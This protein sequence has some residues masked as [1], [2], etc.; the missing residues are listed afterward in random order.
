MATL[1]HLQNQKIASG[2]IGY[3]LMNM[4]TNSS[5]SDAMIPW[6]VSYANDLEGRL[7]AGAR[8]ATFPDIINARLSS[9]TDSAAWRMPYFQTMSAEY[10]GL[11][12]TGIPLLVVAHGVGPMERLADAVDFIQ[13]T[14]HRMRYSERA[15]WRSVVEDA[16]KNLQRKRREGR[17]A[18]D[19]LHYID[20]NTER[21]ACRPQNPRFRKTFLDLVDGVYGDVHIIE[22]RTL[23]HWYR[24][25][26]GLSYDEACDDPLVRVRLGPRAEEYLS[27]LR[28]LNR[29]ISI[30]DEPI[31]Y[32]CITSSD[33]FLRYAD[34][35]R[36]PVGYL[37]DEHLNLFGEK[38]NAQ[39]VGLWDLGFTARFVL[40][41]GGPEPL[42]EIRSGPGDLFIDPHFNQ[43]LA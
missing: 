43:L 27:Q 3:T 37:L 42:Q 41:G 13:H 12:R 10:G 20:Y 26:R 24:E 29:E 19:D 28:E 5:R 21:L 33:T 36:G 35:Q 38:G 2:A 6:L 34:L 32:P 15:I 11:S 4:C 31:Y 8:L 23:P 7:L 40:R 25:F 17:V 16:R 14:S 18:D 30:P 22:M 1:V 9:S 39:R